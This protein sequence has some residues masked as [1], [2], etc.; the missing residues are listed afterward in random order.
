MFVVPFQLPLPKLYQ[1][2]TQIQ[3]GNKHILTQKEMA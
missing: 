1:L 2:V 3:G